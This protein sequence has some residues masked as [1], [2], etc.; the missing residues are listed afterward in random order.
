MRTF[1]RYRKRT[2]LVE[3]EKPSMFTDLHGFYAVRLKEG[4]GGTEGFEE[5]RKQLTVA[6][7]EFE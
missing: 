1:G 2:V 5:L 6:G 4:E 3:Y 7:C